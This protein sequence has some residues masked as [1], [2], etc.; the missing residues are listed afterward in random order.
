[1]EAQLG[2]SRINNTV[3]FLVF[4]I[5]I[6]ILLIGLAFFGFAMYLFFANWGDLDPNFFVGMGTIVMLFGLFVMMCTL[7]GG[8]GLDKQTEKYGKIYDLFEAI[9]LKRILVWQKAA[10]VLSGFFNLYNDLND[11]PAVNFVKCGARVWRCL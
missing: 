10:Y 1:M 7:V 3:K 11:V 2:Q 4:H 5:N 8:Y 6:V 9:S